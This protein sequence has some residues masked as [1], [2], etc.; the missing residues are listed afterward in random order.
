MRVANRRHDLVA[1]SL[2]DPRETELPEVGIVELE[3]A[4]TGEE[5]LVD[6]S[7]P[8]VQMAFGRYARSE[9]EARER[10]FRSIGIDTVEISTKAS[11]VEP[12]MRFF[13]MRASKIRA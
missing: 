11:Y 12:L 9:I 4:E 10:L 13:R 6:F 2:A 7:D 5:I 1:V 3:D 8:E